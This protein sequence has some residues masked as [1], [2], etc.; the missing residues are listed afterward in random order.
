MFTLYT[1]LKLLHIVGATF[2]I[3]GLAT[4]SLLNLRIAREKNP[5]VLAELTRLMRLNG[6]TIIGP[7]SGL[8]LLA[9]IAMLAVAGLGAPLWILWGFAVIILSFALG[10]TL[11]RRS[12]EQVRDLAARADSG[13]ARLSS[14]QRQ[15]TT[16]NVINLLLLL[17][18]VWA[19]VFK[20]SL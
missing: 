20:P 9:G 15:L 11:I 7:S 16:L 6:M 1:L 12:A 13:D 19:M 18:A 3:G 17:S 5:A 14:A 2:W 10:A 8:A 4:F